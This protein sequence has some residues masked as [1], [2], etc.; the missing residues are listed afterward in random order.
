[1][2]AIPTTSLTIAD[3]NR[4]NSAFWAKR[5]TATLY[6]DPIANES[7]QRK[8]HRLKTF[9]AFKFFVV[10]LELED[11]KIFSEAKTSA[12]QSKNAARPR[13]AKLD[14]LLEPILVRDPEIS[15]KGVRQKLR[16]PKY[17]GTVEVQA[18]GIL[19]M[20]VDKN[21]R[22]LPFKFISCKNLQR[23]LKRFKVR[24]GRK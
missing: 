19:Y 14:L 17:H 8:M 23:C 22:P 4:Q 24:R 13:S 7:V 12:T 2:H 9:D 10:E 3:L 5:D 11:L 6:T 15:L 20:P 18:D 1:M 16:D 21:G